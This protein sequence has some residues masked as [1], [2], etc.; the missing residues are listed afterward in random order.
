M[1]KEDEANKREAL[2]NFNL[3]PNMK[4]ISEK[5]KDNKINILGITIAKDYDKLTFDM[6]GVSGGIV[7]ILV[8][9]SMGYSE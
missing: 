1:Y 6:Q 5:G 3:M 2:D 8:G 7:N 9:G 4:F